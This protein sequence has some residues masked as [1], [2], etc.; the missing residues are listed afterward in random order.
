MRFLSVYKTVETGKPPTPDEM[1]RMDKLIAEGMKAGYLL[2][3]EG[4]L[5]TARGARVRQSSG[6]VTV[7]DGPF[8]EAKEVI[9]GLAILK[10]NSKEEAIQMVKDFMKVAGDGECELR[11]L[12]DA[13][14]GA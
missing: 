5:P 2:A 8:A 12:Y 9:G 1:A 6:K 13:D 4:C 14:A 3:V 11:Q 7:T 10:A